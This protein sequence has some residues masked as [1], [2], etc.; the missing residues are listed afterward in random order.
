MTL[1]SEQ[2]PSEARTA[3]AEVLRINPANAEAR[4]AM[5]LLGGR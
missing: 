3:F 4:R 5:V 2:R 1:A